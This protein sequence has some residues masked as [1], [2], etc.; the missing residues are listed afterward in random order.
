MRTNN[1]WVNCYYLD[2]CNNS[3]FFWFNHLKALNQRTIHLKEAKDFL[4]FRDNH[5]KLKAKR[6]SSLRKSAWT[7][8]RSLCFYRKK[9]QIHNKLYSKYI[10]LSHLKIILFLWCTKK[11]NTSSCQGTFSIVKVEAFDSPQYVTPWKRDSIKLCPY[12]STKY[13]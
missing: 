9:N 12:L 8:H 7:A 13:F 4:A 6:I 10:F 2:T 11:C 3:R 5:P 1:L